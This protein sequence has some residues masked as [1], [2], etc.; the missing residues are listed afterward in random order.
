MSTVI[1]A[2]LQLWR[3]KALDG[4]ITQDEMR[5]AIA[6][7]RNER[8]GASKVS[9]A[10]RERKSTTKAKAAPVDSDALLGQLGIDL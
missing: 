1:A 3:Q 7:I 5:E 8:L 4:T 10:S 6:A 2:N 9:D